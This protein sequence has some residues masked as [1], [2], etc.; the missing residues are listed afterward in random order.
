[1]LVTL[2][3][4]QWS[5]GMALAKCQWLLENEGMEVK[6]ARGFFFFFFFFFLI[7]INVT[8]TADSKKSCKNHLASPLSS[9]LNGAI[10]DLLLI[11]VL[12]RP[13]H[14]ARPVI[15]P[16]CFCA[17]WRDS[18]HACRPPL[19]LPHSP[20]RLHAPPTRRVHSC[21]DVWSS[22][23]RRTTSRRGLLQ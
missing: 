17:Y 10:L 21:G 22:I 13:S 18:P 6:L 4:V 12:T 9:R 20:R 8:I 11:L 14:G 15:D 1:M 5:S 23:T 19:N 16:Q 7:D 3:I 2:D